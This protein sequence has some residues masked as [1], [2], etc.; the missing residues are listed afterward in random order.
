MNSATFSFRVNLKHGRVPANYDPCNQIVPACLDAIDS[1]L[2]VPLNISKDLDYE[3]GADV[4]C[5]L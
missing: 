2:L 5:N 1:I 3:L 4:N